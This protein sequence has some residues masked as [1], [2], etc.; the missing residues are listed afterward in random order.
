V[1]RRTVAPPAAAALGAIVLALVAADVRS[2]GGTLD[3]GDA[4]YV[5]RPRAANWRADPLLP[6]DPGGRL[7]R[8]HDD[9]ELRTAL[10]AF[11]LAELTP[12]G[13]DNGE[14]R[15]AARAAAAAALGRVALT[16]DA[17]RASRA[18]DLIGILTATGENPDDEQ[19]QVAFEA[20]V[21][22]DA[23]NEDAKYNLELLLRRT[24]PV[25]ARRGTSTG[26]GPR[27]GR[28]AGAAGA[29]RGY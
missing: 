8:I 20:A 7:L 27:G 3:R 17:A 19:A 26:A 2:W 4:A 24:Q 10:R 13:F 28:G 23:A 9:V 29:G 1:S 5:V 22:A 14:R 6:G 15:A 11:V 16:S 21:R 12:P 18:Y 25:G